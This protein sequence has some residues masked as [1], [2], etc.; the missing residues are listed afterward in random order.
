MGPYQARSAHAGGRDYAAERLACLLYPLDGGLD[1]GGDAVRVGDIADEE[2][3]GGTQFFDE[4]VA[5]PL[6]HVQDYCIAAVGADIADT[7]PAE[8]GCAVPVS[9]RIA[10]LGSGGNAYPPETTK[11]RPEYFIVC[12]WYK[13]NPKLARESVLC[14]QVMPP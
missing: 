1:D 5:E 2:P 9:M 13:R 4:V 10:A 12:G 6:V 8:A 7:G 3:G 14:N 11:V